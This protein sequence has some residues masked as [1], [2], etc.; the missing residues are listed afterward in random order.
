MMPYLYWKMVTKSNITSPYPTLCIHGCIAVVG[1]WIWCMNRATG[2]KSFHG[3]SHNKMGTMKPKAPATWVD[4]CFLSSYFSNIC[5][6]YSKTCTAGSSVIECSCRDMKQYP[7]WVNRPTHRHKKHP[8]RDTPFLGWWIVVLVLPP[9]LSTTPHT[10]RMW[11][12]VAYSTWDSW[13]NQNHNI[14]CWRNQWISMTDALLF[15]V[16][17]WF[18]NFMNFSSINVSDTKTWISTSYLWGQHETVG[19]HI[20]SSWDW[21]QVQNFWCGWLDFLPPWI[22]AP[23]THTFEIINSHASDMR[24]YQWD[25]QIMRCWSDIMAHDAISCV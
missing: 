15:L 4:C 10:T 8:R 1:T 14:G 9:Q 6:N 2:R 21:P 17:C 7:P 19:N 5:I 16:N 13:C 20:Y 24:L 23:W 12:A 3:P 18:R 11:K 22:M 25:L